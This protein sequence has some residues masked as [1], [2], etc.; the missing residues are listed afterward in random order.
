MNYRIPLPLAFVTLA[1]CLCKATSIGC[2]FLFVAC[3]SRLRA[4]GQ[5]EYKQRATGLEHRC[6]LCFSLTLASLASLA[7]LAFTLRE[8]VALG[9]KGKSC[10]LICSLCLVDG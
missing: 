5:S 8:K 2:A 7:S 9:Q 4:R 3:A 1:S 10:V 6:Q